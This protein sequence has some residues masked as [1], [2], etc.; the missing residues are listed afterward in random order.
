MQGVYALGCR[1]QSSL[2][3]LITHCGSRSYL[4]KGLHEYSECHAR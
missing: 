2:L 4:S 1:R 3:T